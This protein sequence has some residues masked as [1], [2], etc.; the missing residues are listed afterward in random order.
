MSTGETLLS[1]SKLNF[2]D[3]PNH[4]AYGNSGGGQC[5]ETLEITS[6]KTFQG[7]FGKATLEINY[8]NVY[9][10]IRRPLIVAEGLDLGAVTSPEFPFGESSLIDFLENVESSRSDPL[11]DLLLGDITIDNDQ[12]YDIIYVNWNDGTD[13]IQRNAYALEA[14]I[15]WVNDQKTTTEENVVIGQSMGGLIARYALKEMEDDP[16]LSHDTRLFVSQDSPHLGA[17][18][19]L[20]YQY[21]ARNGRNQYVQSPVQLFGGDVVLPLFN[22]GVGIS[23]YLGL[24]DEPAVKQMLIKWV[25]RDYAIDNTIHDTWQTTLKNMGY[26]QQT[27][28]VAISNGSQCAITQGFNPGSTLFEVDGRVKT[29]WLTDIFTSFTGIG[30]ISN[31]GTFL[32]TTIFTFEPG[33]LFGVLPGSRKL[34]ADIDIK[35]L[36]NFGQTNQIYSAN[37]TFTK[38]VLWLININVNIINESF[39]SPSNALPYDYYPGGVVSTSIPSSTSSNSNALYGLDINVTSDPDFVLVPTVSALDIGKGFTNLNNS[40]YLNVFRASAPPI[41]PKD[42]PFDNFITSFRETPFLIETLEVNNNEIDITNFNQFHLDLFQVNGNWLADE[43]DPAVAASIFDCSFVCSTLNISG[44]DNLCSSQTYSVQSGNALVSWDTNSSI[45]N[46]SNSSTGQVV[47]SPANSNSRGNVTISATISSPGC[48]STTVSKN[49][50]VGKP[51]ANLPQAPTLCT[52]SFSEPYTLPASD[53]ATSYRLESGSPY[54]KINGQS[55][56]TF[57]NAPVS[58]IYFSSSSPGTYLV[59]L[60]TTNGCGESRGAMYVTSETCGLGGPGGFNVYPNPASNEVTIEANPEKSNSTYETQ[61]L[62]IAPST[63]LAKLYD[64]NGAFVID[65]EL[66]PYGTTKLDVSNLKDGMYF[67][68][69]QGRQEEET[70]KIIVRH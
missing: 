1:H 38:K 31:A 37:V 15:E 55:E 45:I 70:Y 20:G 48:G 69:I 25:D 36:P 43:I 10:E 2:E 18:I 13:Y 27:K 50:Y 42:T 14:V 8:G 67:L 34:T 9:G 65:I 30:F 11:G 35:A 44:S 17:N 6:T 51:Y 49:L 52:N 29:G 16:S 7:S 3:L 4:C 66:D 62:V 41:S 33:F 19:P 12:E 59:E 39:N 60:F 61:S 64:F 53:G 21:A 5:I 32:A 22:N 68:K 58:L 54:L 26:P 57:T 46:L 23:D 47:I 56:V 63:Q 24:L 28:N 40:D